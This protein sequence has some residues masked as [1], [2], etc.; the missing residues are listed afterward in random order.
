MSQATNTPTQ[1]TIQNLQRALPT[2]RHI[3]IE[4]LYAV[5]EVAELLHV[6]RAIIYKQIHEGKLEAVRIGRLFR[7]TRES[8]DNFLHN[9]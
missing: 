7:I 5:E 9:S 2:R 4:E 3:K 6:S 1:A 8:L